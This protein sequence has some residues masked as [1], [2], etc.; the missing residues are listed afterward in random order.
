MA[1]I[2]LINYVAGSKWVPL[3]CLQILAVLRNEGHQVRFL[4][5]QTINDGI[6]KPDLLFDDSEYLLISTISMMLPWLF[7]TTKIIKSKN[8]KIK[9]ILGGPGVSP[10]SEEIL[11]RVDS[12]DYVVEGEG[13]TA[14]V[15]LIR[16]LEKKYD[17][18]QGLGG[19]PNIV[20]RDNNHI[21]R[22]KRVKQNG[23]DSHFADRADINLDDYDIAS[24]IITSYGCPYS[25]SF[26]YNQNMWGGKVQLKPLKQIFDEA[27][28]IL[29]KYNTNHIVFID[30][31]FFISK[32][33][34]YDF[35]NLY[36]TKKCKFK[37]VIL[38][39]RVDSLDDDMLINLKNT[40]CVSLSFGIESASNRILK[41]IDK[42]FTIEKALQT[43]YRAKMYI[44]DVSVSFIVGFP[45][46]EL[47]EFNDT[48]KLAK[49]LYNEGIY[50]MMSFLRPQIGT[51]IYDEYKNELFIGN[52]REVIRPLEIDEEIQKIIKESSILYSWYYTYKTPEL[53][54]KIKT[55]RE[56]N[57]KY[58][59]IHQRIMHMGVQ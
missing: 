24:S 25:C 40:N 33:R 12:V 30:D 1:K 32:K 17:F 48:I 49:S 37:Y 51:K 22:N 26:C 9:I 10:I 58:I 46:E 5:L 43:I 2:T 34:C 13:E 57:M 53:E 39:A 15:E 55:Y 28:Y 31:L 21:I 27:D 3:G 45:F 19:I 7:R 14:V 42:K 47:E 41:K 6:H 52:F 23:Y 11:R 50:V 29:R 16:T 56:I 38:G 35:F 54:E 8:P 18:V 36:N 4:D 59:P 20:Y 44:P